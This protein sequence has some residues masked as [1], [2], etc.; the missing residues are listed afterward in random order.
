MIAIGH[1]QEESG[2]HRSAEAVFATLGHVPRQWMIC[3]KLCF[4]EIVA[5]KYITNRRWLAMFFFALPL[6]MV[7]FL[8]DCGPPDSIWKKTIR[9]SYENRACLPPAN[10][11]HYIVLNV[12]ILD[13]DRNGKECI[14]EAEV[15]TRCKIDVFSPILCDHNPNCI[16][17]DGA[18]DGKGMGIVTDTSR[19]SNTFWFIEQDGVWTIT[20]EGIPKHI[21][22]IRHP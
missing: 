21:A 3:V 1:Y 19:L 9:R 5:L 20:R 15:E 4:W 14:V 18:M 11:D 2:L 22:N 12:D 13:K 6:A 10:G 17:N 8:T 7:T 16:W